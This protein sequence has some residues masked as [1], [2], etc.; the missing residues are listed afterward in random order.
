[1]YAAFTQKHQP[2]LMGG[3]VVQ[4]VNQHLHHRIVSEDDG[5]KI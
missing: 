5:A 1:M 4:M 3:I 2:K